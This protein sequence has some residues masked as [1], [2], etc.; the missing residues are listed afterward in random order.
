MAIGPYFANVQLQVSIPP[1]MDITPP[2]NWKVIDVAFSVDFTAGQ[3]LFAILQGDVSPSDT[4]GNAWNLL[5]TE[6]DLHVWYT[7]GPTN[8][9]PG[10]EILL[11]GALAW[12]FGLFVPSTFMPDIDLTPVQIAQGAL[13][14]SASGISGIDQAFPLP[15]TVTHENMCDLL[16]ASV[17]DTGQPVEPDVGGEPSAQTWQLHDSAPTGGGVS[18]GYGFW[19]YE[20][21]EEEELVLVSKEPPSYGVSWLSNYL[22]CAHGDVEYRALRANPPALGPINH[23]HLLFKSTTSEE[24]GGGGGDEDGVG[25]NKVT[26]IREKLVERHFIA[27]TNEDTALDYQRWSNDPLDDV[28]ENISIDSALNCKSVFYNIIEDGTHLVTYQRSILTILGKSVDQGRS[29]TLETLFTGYTGVASMW[30]KLGESRGILV[31]LLYNTVA[32]SWYCSVGYFDSDGDLQVSTPIL[33]VSGAKA[34]GGSVIQRE[35]GVF[36]FIYTTLDDET[37]IA[38]CDALG[39]D[40]SGSWS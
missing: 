3:V 7:T 32:E 27:L 10:D 13:S 20:L 9:G 40:G 30:G 29:W 16:C 28:E 33:A 39:S 11:G 36:E 5:A 35:D 17:I 25:F 22:V 18:N 24:C 12:S 38:R 26:H 21:N 15:V 14:W 34:V 4:A 6:D 23:I 1:K 37:V 19:T 8:Y 2:D 31:M